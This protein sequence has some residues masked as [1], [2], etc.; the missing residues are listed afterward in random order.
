MTPRVPAGVRRETPVAPFANP[1]FSVILV[2][3]RYP[4]VGLVR[5]LPGRVMGVVVPERV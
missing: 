4:F 3:I 1:Y 2:A 5:T